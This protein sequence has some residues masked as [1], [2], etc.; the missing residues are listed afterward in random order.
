MWLVV[1]GTVALTGLVVWFGIAPGPAE[2]GRVVGRASPEEIEAWERTRDARLEAFRE[3][4]SSPEERSPEELA[5][6]DEAIGWQERIVEA[7]PEGETEERGRLEEWRDLREEIAVAGWW[8]EAREL[9]REG[10]A[11]VAEDPGTALERYRAALQRYERVRD[12][13]GDSSREARRR[14]LSLRREILS[15]EARPLHEESLALEERAEDAAAAGHR[16]EAREL[17]REAAA[18]QEEINRK[19]R[20]ARYARPARASDLRKR[21][22][23]I[24]ARGKAEWIGGRVKEGVALLQEGRSAEARATF[25]RA[26]KEQQSL[27]QSH[28]EVPSAALEREQFLLALEANFAGLAAYRILREREQSLHRTLRSGDIPQARSEIGVLEEELVSFRTQFPSATLPVEP[29]RERIAYLAGR[30]DELGAI[31]TEVRAGLVPAPGRDHSVLRTEVPQDLYK[32]VMG[33]NPSRFVAA[34]QPVEAVSPREAE[35]FLR[36]LGWILANPVRL[37]TLAELEALTPSG[38][39]GDGLP[40]LIIGGQ[41]RRSPV[42]VDAGE[43][44]PHGLYH[45]LGNVAEIATDEAGFYGAYGGSYLDLEEEVRAGLWKDLTATSRAR[46]T[47]FRFVV[48]E[49]ETLPLLPTG[50]ETILAEAEALLAQFSVSAAR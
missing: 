42:A 20:G 49:E 45:L 29:L 14:A 11:R 12:A 24:T 23:E 5:L 35:R 6:L 17:L 16:T 46:T 47:G 48:E 15:L 4:G 9:E 19:Y 41:G 34:D 2:E 25:A 39:Q 10:E 43:T 3:S 1:F 8:E 18:L 30:A 13:G 28:P 38:D 26:L 31:A 32:A 21:G 27:R 44:G 37:P 36:R 40:E 22:E 33:E 7:Q 50:R